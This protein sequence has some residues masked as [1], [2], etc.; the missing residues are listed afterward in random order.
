MAEWFDR[1]Y[2]CYYCDYNLTPHL[3]FSMFF[4]QSGIWLIGHHAVSPVGKL[5]KWQS[6]ADT[7]KSSCPLH[8]SYYYFNHQDRAITHYYY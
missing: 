8:L 3:S 4:E 6:R 1:H 5:K 7:T 2:P